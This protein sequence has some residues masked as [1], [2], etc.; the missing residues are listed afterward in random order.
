[1]KTFHAAAF[2]VLAAGT[3]A[4]AQ[5]VQIQSVNRSASMRCF[6]HVPPDQ[7]NLGE[8]WSTSSEEMGHWNADNNMDFQASPP[9]GSGMAMAHAHLMHNS[10]VHPEMFHADGNLDLN[11]NS[12]GIFSAE[13]LSETRTEIRFFV[14]ERLQM[15][16][17]I[18]I[19]PPGGGGEGGAFA[20]ANV[21]LATEGGVEIINTSEHFD[22]QRVLTAGTY[23]F[24]L[25]ARAESN[26]N[27]ECNSHG[28]AHFNYDMHFMPAP[29]CEADFNG[30]TQVDFF[31][32]LDFAQAFSNEE[33]SADFNH[34]GQVD[35]FDYLDFALAFD[36]G[37]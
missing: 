3:P 37:C 4:F 14:P 24:T 9:D 34:D 15:Q 36:A 23:V 31:D 25:T 18:N 17:N 1:M 11:V 20:I 26:C 12:T 33:P 13:G 7:P 16:C 27:G 28:H 35:F 10:E 6:V 29:P 5:T 19:D 32:Y 30:D 21:T 2:V 22:G 8:E